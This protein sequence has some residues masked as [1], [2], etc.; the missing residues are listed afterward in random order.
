[1]EGEVDLV[2]PGA[3]SDDDMVVVGSENKHVCQKY[4]KLM[5]HEHRD[6]VLPYN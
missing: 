4:L 2:D 5:C 1:M 6:T 3:N